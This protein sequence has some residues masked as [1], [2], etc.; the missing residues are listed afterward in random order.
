[1]EVP[2]GKA[3]QAY[4]LIESM[5]TFLDLAPG[6]L[7]SESML[8]D[9]TGFG[10][11]PVR[12]ALQRLA[13][14]GMVEINPKRGVLVAEL[15]IESQ[16]QL[17]EIHRCLAELTV[18]LA[19]RRADSAQ[20]EAMIQ[21]AEVFKKFTGDDIR[22]YRTLLNKGQA[23]MTAGSHNQFLEMGMGPLVA[24]SVRFWFANLRDPATEL[25]SAADLQTAMLKAIHKQ[26][27][28]AAAKATLQYY[29]YLLE[30]ALRVLQDR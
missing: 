7:V 22:A 25:R 13:N 3:Q 14:Q 8:M 1:M 18:R 6:R 23:L 20:R 12:E 24:P 21:H 16:L 2:V 30:S 10:R 5:I 11:T 19:A 17:L 28:E 9:L 15:S 29:D 26:D 4:E 27:P